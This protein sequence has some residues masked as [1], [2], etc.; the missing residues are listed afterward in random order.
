LIDLPKYMWFLNKKNQLISQFLDVVG[1]APTPKLTRQEPERKQ[2][3]S[4][5][6][7]HIKDI[8]SLKI[9]TVVQQ[10]GTAI[11]KGKII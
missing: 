8:Y 2:I 3:A 5:F 10:V 1:G 6:N 7:S 9:L 11:N 4:A